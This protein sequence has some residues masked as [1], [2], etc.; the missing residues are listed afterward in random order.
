MRGHS[1]S[2]GEMYGMMEKAF[3]KMIK[4]LLIGTPDRQSKALKMHRIDLGLMYQNGRGVPQNDKEAVDW[5][6]KAAEQG[7]AGSQYSLGLMYGNGRGVPQDDKQAVHWYTKSAEQG[8]AEAQNNLGVMYANG[9]GVPQD[10]KEAVDL[11]TKA[12]KQGFA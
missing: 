6:T 1:F 7:F 8:F 10:D 5:F 9:R 12:A 4:R 2:L 11:Y 3:R